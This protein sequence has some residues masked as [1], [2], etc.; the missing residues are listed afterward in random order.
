VEY[1]SVWKYRLIPTE[2]REMEIDIFAKVPQDK[3]S[4]ATPCPGVMTCN[5]WVS[6]NVAYFFIDNKQ[7]ICL[8]L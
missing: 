1:E 2:K 3:Y 7:P 4:L 5:G 8:A 6:E